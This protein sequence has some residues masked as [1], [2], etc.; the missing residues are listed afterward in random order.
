MGAHQWELAI[1]PCTK[2]KN[3]QATIARSLYKS[4]G[5]TLMM[6]HAMQ[7]A[8]RILIMSAFY[9]LLSLE[10]EV[11]YYDAYL[12]D[13]SEVQRRALLTRLRAHTEGLKETKILSYLPNA[14]YATLVA[15]RPPLANIID[16][17]YKSLS[18][19]KLFAVLKAEIIAH[20][21]AHSVGR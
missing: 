1:I 8:D 21:R 17:P 12:P 7:R 6:Q 14:Y 16:R 11:A 5:F 19:M 18:M 3:P 20:E 10:D 13:L 4:S 2:S 9:G 15:A